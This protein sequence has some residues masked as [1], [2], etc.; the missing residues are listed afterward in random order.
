MKARHFNNGMNQRKGMTLIEVLACV[1][2]FGFIVSMAGP[3]M[4]DF[5]EANKRI[6]RG[7]EHVGELDWL[8]RM[9]RADVAKAREIAPGNAVFELGNDTLILRSMPRDLEG[10]PLE[11]RE[12]YVI[13]TIDS[14]HPSQLLRIASS[15][16]GDRLRT[17][18]RVVA[19]N[20]EEVA[21]LYGPEDE[22]RKTSVELRMT[23]KKGIVHKNKP[24][25]YSIFAI[26]GE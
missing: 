5:R 21:F 13:Y 4:F 16:S 6:A 1:A 9:F 24:M 11:S 3:L 26:V 20:L 7:L 8:N 12:E 23:F 10:M 2:L 14:K 22:T 19:R 18:S 15:W 25:F 17:T